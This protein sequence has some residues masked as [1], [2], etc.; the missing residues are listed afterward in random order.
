MG[1]SKGIFK[2]WPG[3]RNWPDGKKG[4][5]QQWSNARLE[6]ASSQLFK[7]ATASSMLL[8]IPELLPSLESCPPAPAKPTS[9]SKAHQLT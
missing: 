3:S 7:Q 9:T 2:N 8:H 1:A 6:G 5:I 4:L